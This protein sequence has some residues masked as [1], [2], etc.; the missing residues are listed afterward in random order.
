M[1]YFCDGA[2]MGSREFVEGIFRQHREKFGKRRKD[3]ARR[4]KG[5]EAE[6]L[7]TLRDLR[8]GLFG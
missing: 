6:A 5:V 1:R 3:G 8:K 2:A 4:M 7:F